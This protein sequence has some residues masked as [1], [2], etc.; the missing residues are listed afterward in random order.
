MQCVVLA[1]GLA[2]RMRPRTAVT[3]KALLPLNGKPFV[4]YQLSLLAANG[5]SRVV[6]CIGYL[7][8]MIRDVVGDGARW[9]LTVEYV[10][11]GD[12]LR[13]TAG[14][15][16]LAHD[17][18]CLEAEFLVLYGD[19]YLPI[20]Y[21]PVLEM[22]QNMPRSK[23]AAVMTVLRNDDRWDSSNVLFDGGHLVVYDKQRRDQFDAAAMHHVD[24][25]VSALRRDLVDTHVAPGTVADLADLFHELSRHGLLAGYEVTTRFYE[26][27]SPDGLAELEAELRSLAAGTG[28][29]AR[30][31][32]DLLLHS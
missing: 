12:N 22:L 13:G 8:D 19:S 5:V 10:D 23:A 11:E 32:A 31:R 30:Q 6:L 9:G 21:R 29:T 15:L 27:G 25:G 1:G 20:D 4:D 18:G 17:A 2:T 14:A 3:P 16:R 26:I 7:G 24:Y 28:T